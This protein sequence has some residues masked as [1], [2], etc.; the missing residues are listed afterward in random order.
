MDMAT[1]LETGIMKKLVIPKIDLNK[2]FDKK[3]EKG[4]LSAKTP[5]KKL[6]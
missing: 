6:N 1:L 2:T 3:D 4:R 5:N